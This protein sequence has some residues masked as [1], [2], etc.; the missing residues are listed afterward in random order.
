MPEGHNTRVHNPKTAKTQVRKATFFKRDI[1]YMIYMQ[2]P[3]PALCEVSA[4]GLS[5]N[6]LVDKWV[7]GCLRNYYDGTLQLSTSAR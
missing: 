7:L 6:L 4:E 2:W 1:S 3:V 5:C